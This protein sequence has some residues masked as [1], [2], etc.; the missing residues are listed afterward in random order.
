[1]YSSLVGLDPYWHQYQTMRIINGT[2]IGLQS[3]PGMYYL[4]AFVMKLF[5]ISYR[6]AAMSVSF[7]QVA[8]DAIL[9]YYIGKH[10]L[11]QRVGLLASLVVV[12]SGWHIFF[13]F[14]T[15]PN[16]LGMTFSLGI[17]Y[18]AILNQEKRR[19]YLLFAMLAGMVV[20]VCTHTISAT[21]GIA[22][23]GILAFCQLRG[24]QWKYPLVVFAV[25]STIVLFVW[26][27]CGFT[28][29]LLDMMKLKFSPEL[30]GLTSLPATSSEIVSGTGLPALSSP[31]VAISPP[32]LDNFINTTV[33]APLWEILVNTSGMII[34]FC[35]AVLG[36]ILLLSRL[37]ISRNSL[38]IVLS[39]GFFLSVGFFPMFLGMSFVEHRWWYAAQIFASLPMAV[40][41]LAI[42]P[43]A[44]RVLVV[45]GIVIL[46]F[47]MIMGLP[48]NMDN[49]TFSKN[50]LVCY[51]LKDSEIEAV[52]YIMDNY[53]GMVG[54][55]AYYTLS[56]H[57]FPEYRERMLNVTN[58]FMAKDLSHTDCNIVLVRNNFAYEPFS[59]GEG[60]I[61]KLTYDP[62]AYLQEVGWEKIFENDSVKVYKRLVDGV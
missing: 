47:L 8:G 58:E 57:I 23:L 59:F 29:T 41:C 1:M 33:R 55:D 54:M 24:K 19:V 52:E 53:E 46:C 36:C 56:S 51:A 42:R 60:G 2:S 16:I 31:P 28:G 62:N 37:L 50:Q 10:L 14:W 34:G 13:G 3:M 39:F 9:I 15:I 32:P 38:F 26:Y 7:I 27:H 22:L 17:L 4:V 5:G 43:F 25:C 30:L 49:V 20:L 45:I 6:L 21:W 18:L 48:A 40:F 12:F 35:L 61:F 44:G 11:N